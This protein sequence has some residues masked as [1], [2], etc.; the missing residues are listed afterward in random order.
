MSRLSREQMMK[1]LPLYFIAGSINCP[2]APGEVLEEAI[3][4][5]ITLFQFREKGTGAHEGPAKKA[6]ADELQQICRAHHIPFLV[7]DDVD[8][9]LELDADGV[10]IG[11]DDESVESVR[12]RIGNKILGVSAHT[13]EEAEL[14]ISQ[15]ADYLGIGPVYPTTTKED[16]RKAAGFTLIQELRKSG[17]HI[18]IVGIG[19]INQENSAAVIGAGADGVSV[20]SAISNAVD[21]CLAA[22]Q[23]KAT[24]TGK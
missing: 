2:K 18:P 3:A 12:R 14:A 15:G 7:N 17:N 19:G 13:M 1:L 6:L 5:G 22:Q 20:I 24:I 11:Q 10:H 23:I 9:A 16:A 4:G 8:L 21:V